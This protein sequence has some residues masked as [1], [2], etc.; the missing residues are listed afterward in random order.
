[1][2]DVFA[3]GSY[4]P[5]TCK[6]RRPTGSS[7]FARRHE[8]GAIVVVVPHLPC[9][10]M[11]TQAI[12]LSREVLAGNVAR[13]PFDARLMAVFGAREIDGETGELPLDSLFGDGPVAVMCVK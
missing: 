6:G 11:D 1:M 10:M 5:L 8:S 7:L 13:L 3:N 9:A 2:P 4:E 12:S